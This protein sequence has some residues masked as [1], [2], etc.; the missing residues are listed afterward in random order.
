MKIPELRS[1]F[2]MHWAAHREEFDELLREV[3]AIPSPTGQEQ[4]KAA[5]VRDAAQ[6]AGIETACIDEVGNVVAH[7]AGSPGELVLDAHLD[8]VFPADTPLVV[9]TDGDTWSAPSIGDDSLAV[10]TLLYL[11]RFIREHPQ[12]R[13]PAVSALW[14]VGEE[15]LGNLRGIRH[16]V[17]S[18]AAHARGILALEGLGR[19]RIVSQ[20]VGS[21]RYRI[22]VGC[23]GGHS[24]SD[25]GA[26]SA[27]HV[28]AA[29]IA[30]VSGWAVPAEPRT[31]F[32]VGLVCGGQSINTIAPEAEF[33]LDL[34]SLD[35]GRL[36]VLE[37]ALNRLAAEKAGADGVETNVYLLG[38]RPA[39]SLS[40]SSPLVQRSAEI[41]RIL[42]IEPRFEPGSTSVN[43]PLARG[44][45]SLCI[46]I[47]DGGG[48]HTLEEHIRHST[49]Q[50][51]VEKAILHAGLCLEHEPLQS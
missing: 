25:F 5:F 51:G 10:V 24:W 48:A 40:E 46:G 4:R 1:A 12:L 14:S 26:P 16:A 39:G 19:D 3:V 9:R 42:E 6:A 7:L 37:D 8:T 44:I 27:I 50:A 23:A 2:R 45:P 18:W 33:F 15:G 11:C 28:A 30:A 13:W 32:N 17:D 47:A 49:V 43:I 34:R 20:G 22:T 31:T 29:M 21:R 41:H 36:S 35:E 38:E